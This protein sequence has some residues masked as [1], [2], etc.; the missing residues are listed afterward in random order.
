MRGWDDRDSY[1]PTCTSKDAQVAEGSFDLS[2]ACPAGYV[3]FMSRTFCLF[4]CRRNSS[5]TR[6]FNGGGVALTPAPTPAIHFAAFWENERINKWHLTEKRF[7]ARR[8]EG[9]RRKRGERGGREGPRRGGESERE[10]RQGAEEGPR[11]LLNSPRLSLRLTRR[12]SL[13]CLLSAGRENETPCLR[14]R[15]TQCHPTNP[16]SGREKSGIAGHRRSDVYTCELFFP[17]IASVVYFLA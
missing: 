7:Y 3:P 14:S 16:A 8:A 4:S 11:W 1:L 6:R 9:T 13:C 17:P 10:K 5:K 12:T 15:V 2:T